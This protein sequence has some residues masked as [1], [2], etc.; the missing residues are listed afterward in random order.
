MD[1]I[2]YEQKKNLICISDSNWRN[3]TPGPGCTRN[4]ILGTWVLKTHSDLQGGVFI[5][6]C[7][8]LMF[9]ITKLFM[10]S[11]TK[12]PCLQ[13]L[14]M[15]IFYP[16]WNRITFPWARTHPEK[17]HQLATH[18]KNSLVS[19]Q[20]SALLTAISP[21]FLSPELLCIFSSPFTSAPSRLQ[22]A[23]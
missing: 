6:L 4:W 14:W 9:T 20:G 18:L 19:F 5:Y 7:A 22:H 3:L 1:L 2:F 23:W 12:T 10:L 11:W 13:A 15:C 16:E 21:A 17:K 8:F